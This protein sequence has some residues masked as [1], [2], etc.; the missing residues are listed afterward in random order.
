MPDILTL[1]A[2]PKKYIFNLT[3]EVRWRQEEGKETDFMTLLMKNKS[4]ISGLM[5][6]CGINIAIDLID[7]IG[8]VPS[9]PSSKFSSIKWFILLGRFQITNHVFSLWT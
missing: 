7:G 3:L 6:A 2:K 1:H 8:H 9:I 4:T 5:S